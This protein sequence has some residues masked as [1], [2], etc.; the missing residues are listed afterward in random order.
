MLKGEVFPCGLTTRQGAPQR[1]YRHPYT[2]TGRDEAEREAFAAFLAAHGYTVAS[3]TV[4]C[5]DSVFA[6]V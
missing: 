4:A 6:C 1:Y 5:D 3:F 2:Q